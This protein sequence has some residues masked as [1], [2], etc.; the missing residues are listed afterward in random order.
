MTESPCR[1]VKRVRANAAMCL[2]CEHTERTCGDEWRKGAKLCIDGKPAAEHAAAGSCPI[3]R[4][5]DPKTRR[6]RW[7]GV[8]WRG[9]PLPVRL[10]ARLMHPKH[11]KPKTFG[12]CGCIDK[13]KSAWERLH[14]EIR[15]VLFG[16]CLFAAVM[17]LLGSLIYG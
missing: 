16:W 5:M 8:S 11:P 10:Y 6:I 13:F 1:A 9:V 12:D 17:V 4:H 7:M 15:T 14:P 3:G 2:A